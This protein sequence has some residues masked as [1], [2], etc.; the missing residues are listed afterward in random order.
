MRQGPKHTK[1]GAGVPNQSMVPPAIENW[2]RSMSRDIDAPIIAEMHRIE[3]TNQR[4]NSQY[5]RPLIEDENDR[6]S[7]NQKDIFL[8]DDERFLNV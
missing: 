3:T 5:F 1:G 4:F 7:Q 8:H 6:R 2:N